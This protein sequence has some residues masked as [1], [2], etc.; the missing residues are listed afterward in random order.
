ML[1]QKIKDYFSRFN[2]FLKRV[3]IPKVLNFLMVTSLTLVY[4]F[5][6]GATSLFMRLIKPSLFSSKRN[7]WLETEDFDLT[8]ENARRQS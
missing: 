6:L 5:A 3:F 4:L 8:I 7:P 2:Y 1:L